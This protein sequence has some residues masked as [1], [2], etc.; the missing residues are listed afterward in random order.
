MKI[1]TEQ[2]GGEQNFCQTLKE[3]AGGRDA[4]EDTE[5]RKLELIPPFLDA[6]KA[7][8]GNLDDM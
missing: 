5:G 8:Q 4:I 1:V 7:F 3:I 6:K 2:E